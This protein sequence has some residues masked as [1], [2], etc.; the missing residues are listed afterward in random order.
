MPQLAFNPLQE[1]A[2][3]HLDGPMMV[4]S[5]AGSGKTS[6]LTQRIVHLIDNQKINPYDLLAITFAKKAVLEILNRLK[7]KLN[8][9]SEKVTVAT[10]HSLGYRILKAA[11]YPNSGFKILPN[12]EQTGLISEALSKA[13]VKGETADFL[14]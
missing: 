14:R 4:L 3:N 6:V 12:G 7:K 11:N 1:Q 8:G 10:F 5:V 9:T 13:Q 2:I